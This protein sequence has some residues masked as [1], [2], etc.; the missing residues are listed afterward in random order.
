MAEETKV[1]SQPESTP[2]PI[3][4]RWKPDIDDWSEIDVDAYK[5]TYEMGKERLEETLEASYVIASI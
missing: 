1:V 3:D 4:E 2:E 5:L